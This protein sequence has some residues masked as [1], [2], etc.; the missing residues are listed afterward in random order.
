MTFIRIEVKR[1]GC[2][3]TKRQI[4]KTITML[5]SAHIV[6]PRNNRSIHEI[7]DDDIN[8]ASRLAESIMK[9]A[10]KLKRR[11]TLRLLDLDKQ[12]KLT[13]SE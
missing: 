13:H 10:A 1:R 4:Q 11:K 12:R 5:L 8:S 3:T 6:S 7:S 2:M 9:Q